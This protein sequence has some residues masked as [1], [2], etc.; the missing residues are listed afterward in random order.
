MRNHGVRGRG[1]ALAKIAPGLAA[2][3]LGL[4][5]V[6]EAVLASSAAE[7]GH[8]CECEATDCGGATI[9]SS[10][11]CADDEF[12]SCQKVFM[13]GCIVAIKAVCLRPAVPA[14]PPATE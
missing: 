14:P 7:E 4:L 6:G 11:D 5:L 2:A 8:N 13:G 3:A 10:K 12:C 1:F 9:R